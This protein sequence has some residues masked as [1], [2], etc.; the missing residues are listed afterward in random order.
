MTETGNISTLADCYLPYLVVMRSVPRGE[1][2]SESVV[3]SSFGDVRE[4]RLRINSSCRLLV[5]YAIYCRR[6]RRERT[7]M[8]LRQLKA[9]ALREPLSK[10]PPVSLIYIH[11]FLSAATLRLHVGTLFGWVRR[12]MGTSGRFQPFNCTNSS[13]QSYSELMSRGRI[14]GGLFT[15]LHVLIYLCTCERR[16]V[17]KGSMGN[18]AEIPSRHVQTPVPGSTYLPLTVVWTRKED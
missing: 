1:I 15:Y 3:R 10:L 16:C 11:F 14:L 17:Q 4:V 6:L 12:V 9:E 18:L 13:T 7:H 5:M 8:R 2:K